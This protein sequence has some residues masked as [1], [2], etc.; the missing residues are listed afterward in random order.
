MKKHAATLRSSA[1]ECLTY[2]ASI[3]NSAEQFEILY[4]DENI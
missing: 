2:I 4:Q 1:A 3:G